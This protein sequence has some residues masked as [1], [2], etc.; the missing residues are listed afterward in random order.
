MRKLT[1]PDLTASLTFGTTYTDP[2]DNAP[3][4]EQRR[5][6]SESLYFA[7]VGNAAFLRVKCPREVKATSG[8]AWTDAAMSAKVNCFINN[9]Y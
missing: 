9:Y 7:T 8:V 4:D 5:N 3:N 2:D 1:E 6:F